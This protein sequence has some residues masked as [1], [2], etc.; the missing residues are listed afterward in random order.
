MA[1]SRASFHSKQFISLAR[2]LAQRCWLCPLFPTFSAMLW[3]FC[4]F[5]SVFMRKEKCSFK[6][7]FNLP[8]LLSTLLYSLCSMIRLHS[9]M[10][11]YKLT[12]IA[13]WIGGVKGRRRLME[14]LQAEKEAQHRKCW[15]S[16]NTQHVNPSHMR[17]EPRPD[18]VSLCKISSVHV[19]YYETW[20][21]CSTK[22]EQHN[23]TWQIGE[24]N[25][26]LPRKKNTFYDKYMNFA[27]FF[28]FLLVRMLDIRSNGPLCKTHSRACAIIFQYW[29][30]RL[31]K[32]LA[33]DKN[34]N[35]SLF[36]KGG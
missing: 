16:L 4:R 26:N 12:Q 21:R 14:A 28:A 17:A 31:N 24:K 1:S 33:W 6:R 25:E 19:I 18:D 3:C 35:C 8:T 23:P 29:I 22:Y 11:I 15:L 13:E 32:G 2:I 5:S 10:T 30:L 20:C 34:L 7:G 27:P 36:V 9:N